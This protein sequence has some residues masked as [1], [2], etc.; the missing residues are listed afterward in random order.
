MPSNTYKKPRSCLCGYTTSY[1]SAWYS[2]KQICKYLDEKKKNFDE[3]I[4]KLNYTNAAV[5]KTK[6]EQLAAMKEQL[7]IMKEQLAAK[8]EQLAAKDD[9]INELI[10]TH[11]KQKTEDSK[12]SKGTK[13]IKRPEP[14]RR[15][16]AQRQNWKCADP[17][18]VCRLKDKQLEEYDVDHIIRPS[19]GGTDTP[20]NLQALCPACHRKKTELEES[21]D[22]SQFIINQGHG[23]SSKSSIVSCEIAST[24]F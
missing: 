11:K 1:P 8:D 24:S 3:E 21:E 6:D 13:R 19:R 7:A 5:L 2:H 4:E 17:F 15:K 22:L 10:Q 23:A 14:Q 20:E 18:G 9:Q 16:I 12:G